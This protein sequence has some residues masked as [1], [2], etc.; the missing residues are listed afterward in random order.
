[1]GN[2]ILKALAAGLGVAGQAMAAKEAQDREDAI[3]AEQ[4]ARAD[5]EF[6]MK[7]KSFALANQAAKT[8]NML[9]TIELN[10]KRIAQTFASSEGDYGTTMDAINKYGNVPRKLQIDNTLTTE[11]TV[12]YTVGDWT[13][14]PDGT[15]EKNKDGSIAFTAQLDAEGDP[16]QRTLTRDQFDSMVM[17]TIKPMNQVAMW[18]AKEQAEAGLTLAQRQAQQVSDI[19]V[20]EQ[21]KLK[22]VAK[23]QAE[24]D[25]LKAEEKAI[26]EKKAEGT[27]AQQPVSTRRGILGDVKRTQKESDSDKA[28]M[29]IVNK[30]YTNVDP[31]TAFKITEVKSNPTVRKIFRDSAEDVVKGKLSDAEFIN[32]AVKSGLPQEFAED[33]LNQYKE[34]ASNLTE[35]K[36]GPGL[37]ARTWDLLFK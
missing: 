21:K 11:G 18:I 28:F 34:L 17:K 12:T 32:D 14:R 9:S 13:K 8:Q 37:F 16:V 24:I 4:K 1:M 26:G 10:S 6:A 23:T 20:E 15:F 19:K 29:T 27:P 3:R 5:K 30:T 7:E 22:K 35:A 25:K 31:D 2:K 36:R 33:F